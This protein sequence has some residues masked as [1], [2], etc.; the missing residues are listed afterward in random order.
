MSTLPILSPQSLKV[1][2]EK[3]D[4]QMTD[5]AEEKKHIQY[6]LDN[7]S[8]LNSTQLDLQ[9]DIETFD[10]SLDTKP[11]IIE[12]LKRKTHT[13]NWQDIRNIFTKVKP[14]ISENTF[15]TSLG[16]LVR[17]TKHPVERTKPGFY[18]YKA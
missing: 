6:V 16:E 10:G 4:Q 11:L 13:M 3:L 18:K 8:F 14:N 15:K 5:I 1:K 9:P 2:L 12:I 7:F 17:S